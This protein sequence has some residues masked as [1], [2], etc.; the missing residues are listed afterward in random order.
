MDRCEYDAVGVE[1]ND[2]NIGTRI[3][4][5]HVFTSAWH[6]VIILSVLILGELKVC[7]VCVDFELVLM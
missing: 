2:S 4:M 7:V 1:H 6:G 5:C 3:L